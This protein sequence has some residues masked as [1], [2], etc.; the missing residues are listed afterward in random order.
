MAKSGITLDSG[1][2][3]FSA[4][5]H[6]TKLGRHIDGQMKRANGLIGLRLAGQAKTR[7]TSG[8]GGYKRNAGLTR[9]IKGSESPLA[10]HGDLVGQIK[11]Q[12]ISAET[13][14]IGVMKTSHLADIAEVLHTGITID[15]S[16]KMRAM[17][18]ILWLKSKGYPVSLTGRAQELWDRRPQRGWQKLRDDKTAIVIPPRPYF[19][20]ILTDP[21]VRAWIQEQWGFALK[22]AFT[23]AAK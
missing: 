11:H 1:W 16:T 19:L 15:V 7:I 22:A 2:K 3:K 10:D 21:A 13:V 12:V 6:P 8:S 20:F 5:L 14:E 18:F 23:K 4:M 9:F 17:F